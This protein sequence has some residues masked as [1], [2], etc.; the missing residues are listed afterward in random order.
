[1]RVSIPLCNAAW[2]S[3]GGICVQRKWGVWVYYM[4]RE[5]YFVHCQE[6]PSNYSNLAKRGFT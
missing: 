1:M 4:H 3:R 5:C 6:T 2:F